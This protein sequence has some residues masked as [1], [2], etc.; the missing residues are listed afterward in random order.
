MV[1]GSEPV[2]TEPGDGNAEVLKAVG[3]LE[4]DGAVLTADRKPVANFTIAR[5]QR[6]VQERADGKRTEYFEADVG[7]LG[8][9]AKWRIEGPVYDPGSWRRASQG[10]AVIS[11]KARFAGYLQL[12]VG[13]WDSRFVPETV[14]SPAPITGTY[15]NGDQELVVGD[16]SASDNS[17]SLGL[18]NSLRILPA[19]GSKDVFGLVA[20][21]HTD[22][23]VGALLVH[24]LGAVFKPALGGMYPHM[25]VTGD[26]GSGKSTILGEI[27]RRFGFLVVDAVAQFDTAYEKA[28]QI[29][30]D[31]T[32]IA[33]FRARVKAIQ[34]EWQ[35]GFPS[36]RKEERETHSAGKAAAWPAYSGGRIPRADPGSAGR[37]GRFCR[38]EQG[39]GPRGQ[40]DEEPARRAQHEAT[41]LR[42][43]VRSL[44]E[45]GA[46]VPHDDG[47]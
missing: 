4:C 11:D 17:G 35:T 47:E 44:A 46:V 45:H 30:Q 1:S 32:R 18:Y 14:V 3:L 42:P 41:S 16:A 29:V 38:C 25:G 7:L 20:R 23:A 43:K 21:L 9:R 12:I 8:G 36:A 34:Q 33:G 15:L 28:K 2:P 26:R 5:I 27:S 39:A 13:G 19:A 10:L 24:G 40:E 37:T 6:G 31:A 22:G